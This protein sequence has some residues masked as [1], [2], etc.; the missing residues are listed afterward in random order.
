MLRLAPLAHRLLGGEGMDDAPPP[1]DM[2]EALA[3]QL[4][5]RLRAEIDRRVESH[6]NRESMWRFFLAMAG[7]W[8]TEEGLLTPGAYQ[9]LKPLAA[10]V[11]DMLP[12]RSLAAVA[13]V[14]RRR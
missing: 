14:A 10:K 4:L 6:A 2:G 1:I 13:A 8:A 7:S 12:R 3:R 9:A 5:D 11:Y